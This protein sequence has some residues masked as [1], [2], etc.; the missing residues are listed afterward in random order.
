ME[1]SRFELLYLDLLRFS[2]V[3][4]GVIDLYPLGGKSRH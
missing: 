1:Y 3:M 2:A 4:S